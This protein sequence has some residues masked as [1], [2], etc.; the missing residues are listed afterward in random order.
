MDVYIGYAKVVL[1]TIK[2][3]QVLIAVVVGGGVSWYFTRQSYKQGNFRGRIEFIG[4]EPTDD[5]VDFHTHGPQMDLSQVVGLKRLEQLMIA[6]TKKMNGDEILRLPKGVDQ[7]RMMEILEDWLTGND[8]RANMAALKKRP[9]HEDRVGFCPTFY[10]EEGDDAMIRVF[11]FDPEWV[12]KLT[13]E[14]VFKRQHARKKRFAY[15]IPL[16][17]QI[18]KEAISE[19]SKSG[20][21]AAVWHTVVKTAKTELHAA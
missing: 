3:L 7:R 9:V 17:L 1:E 14:N 8:P 13:D 11:V 10:K 16:M 18:A 6:G 15:R 19:R 20:E 12:G 2:H 21:T 5:G 4:V